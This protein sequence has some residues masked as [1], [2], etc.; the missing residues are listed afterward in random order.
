MGVQ[1]RAVLHFLVSSPLI[2]GC[3]S[4]FLDETQFLP[5]VG[6]MFAPPLPHSLCFLVLLQEDSALFLSR[7][8]ATADWQDR[9]L[10]GPHPGGWQEQNLWT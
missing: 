7:F 4:A 5:T 10:L 1:T 3:M 6:L 9:L 8:P 2:W